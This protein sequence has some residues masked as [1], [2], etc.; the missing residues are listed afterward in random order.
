MRSSSYVITTLAVALL[1]CAQGGRRGDDAGDTS[2]RADTHVSD[3]IVAPDTG[4]IDSS[5][6]DSSQPDSSAPSCVGTPSPCAS[7][8]T[9]DCGAQ[10]GC[11]VASGCTGTRTDCSM[12]TDTFDCQLDQLCELPFGASMC[13]DDSR[14]CDSLADP[15]T[16]GL[17]PSCFWGEGCA[18]TATACTGLSESRCAAQDGCA[19]M[20]F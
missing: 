16:C 20:S 8:T 19:V 4:N 9:S 10:L 11:V 3:T 1:A 15:T 14:G 18:G 5:Q 2:I 12:Y 17:S 6:P 13:Q 7:R